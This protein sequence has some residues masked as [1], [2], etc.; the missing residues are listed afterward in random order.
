MT[1][2]QEVSLT[3]RSADELESDW[4]AFGAHSTRDD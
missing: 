3:A 4:N 2:P 1:Q